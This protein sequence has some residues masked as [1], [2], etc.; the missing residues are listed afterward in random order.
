MHSAIKAPH[1]T[2]IHTWQRTDI[3]I[4]ALKQ[5]TVPLHW[6]YTYIYMHSCVTTQECIHV[7]QLTAVILL[8]VYI[9][10]EP[11]IHTSISGINMYFTSNETSSSM[12]VFPTTFH[13]LYK[14]ALYKYSPQRYVHLYFYNDQT[15]SI[16]SVICC[17]LDIYLNYLFA[18]TT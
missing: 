11:H 4:Y 13:I 15:T 14:C 18:Q 10:T 12:I 1:W 3:H 2:C 7:W 17:W 16:T 5:G 6:T 8:G 9:Y